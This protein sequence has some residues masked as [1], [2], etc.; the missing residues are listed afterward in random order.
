MRC[1]AYL[2]TLL[3]A[4]LTCAHASAQRLPKLTSG[5]LVKKTIEF[6]MPQ[7]ALLGGRSEEYLRKA[8][9]TQAPIYAKAV[10]IKRLDPKCVRARIT[11]TI[12]DLIVEASD[13][14]D[15]TKKVKGPFETKSEGNFCDEN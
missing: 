7:E 5:E 1:T 8:L 14:S 13:P 15:P 6:N 3:T 9:N 10:I 11:I 4:C 12:P 2:V